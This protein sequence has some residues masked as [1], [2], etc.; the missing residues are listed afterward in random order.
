MPHT[1]APVVLHDVA[2]VLAQGL[3]VAQPGFRGG[4]ETAAWQLWDWGPTE[5]S[6]RWEV[7]RENAADTPQWVLE[8]VAGSRP[9]C[10]SPQVRAPA[11][12]H[13]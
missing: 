6:P 10:G 3:L 9:D 11:W 12:E 2:G 4:Q 13:L 7:L 1:E 5:Q 8:N